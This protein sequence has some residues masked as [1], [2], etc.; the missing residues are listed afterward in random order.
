MIG[1]GPRRLTDTHLPGGITQKILHVMWNC[2][3]WL[4]LGSQSTYLPQTQWGVDKS[5]T[6]SSPGWWGEGVGH[7]ICQLRETKP[8]TLVD[9]KLPTCHEQTHKTPKNL[10]IGSRKLERVRSGALQHRALH[11]SASRPFW[12]NARRAAVKEGK[13]ARVSLQFPVTAS[14]LDWYLPSC[15]LPSPD[16]RV[17]NRKNNTLSNLPNPVFLIDS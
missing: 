11:F 7:R 17:R 9:F 8:L 2:R 1:R 4:F 12:G 10:T 16:L 14:N 6:T 15:F 3:I 13:K 5:L